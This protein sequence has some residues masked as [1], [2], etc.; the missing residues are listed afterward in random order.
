MAKLS[1]EEEQSDWDEKIDC[2]LMGY[3]A[4]FQS[5]TKHSPYYMLFQQNM[6][7]PV[8][9]ESFQTDKEENSDEVKLE[10]VMESLLE[11]RKKVF[12]EVAINITKA[13]EKQK[14]TYDRKHELVTINRGAEVLLENTAQKQRK[15]GKLEPAWLGPY[16]VSRLLYELSRNGKIVKTKANIARLKVYKKKKL[17][18]DAIA[19]V[20]R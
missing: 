3:R 7:L 1:N 13:Q 5:S 12:G 19:I 16:I 15:G 11:S 10:E 18:R 17:K 4:S 9:S 14:N 2:A 6:R 20:R 8:D